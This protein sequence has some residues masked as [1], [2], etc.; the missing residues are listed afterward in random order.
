MVT[1]EIVIDDVVAVQ[2]DS[3]SGSGVTVENVTAFL[4]LQIGKKQWQ[5][6]FNH[7]FAC[8]SFIKFLRTYDAITTDEQ[9]VRH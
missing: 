3:E 5:T 4:D 1:I 8:K 7:S 9:V 6:G 2:V